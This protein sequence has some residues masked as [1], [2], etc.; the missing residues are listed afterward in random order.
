[1]AGEHERSLEQLRTA[2]ILPRPLG[3][4]LRAR[5]QE[6]DDSPSNLSRRYILQG[7]EAEGVALTDEDKAAIEEDLSRMRYENDP[8]REKE[9]WDALARESLG[10]VE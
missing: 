2:V 7:L 8:Q 5:A 9:G 6:I 4:I 3:E 1:M 10:R